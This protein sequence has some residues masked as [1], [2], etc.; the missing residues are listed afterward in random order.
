MYKTYIPS[1]IRDRTP[2][3]EIIGVTIDTWYTD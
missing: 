2:E 3:E 1:A